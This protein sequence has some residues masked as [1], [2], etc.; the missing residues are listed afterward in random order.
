MAKN[1]ITDP[2][3]D[4]LNK[5]IKRYLLGN[6]GI[7]ESHHAKIIYYLQRCLDVSD[8]KISP[9]VR[10]EALTQGQRSG[11][12]CCLSG[13]T[14]DYDLVGQEHSEAT[15]KKQPDIEHKWPRS[16]GGSSF[17][18]N[19]IVSSVFYNR[20]KSDRIDGSD[21][22]YETICLKTDR[23]SNKTSFESEFD[24]SKKLAVL[25][26]QDY[27][28]AVCGK[29]VSEVGPLSFSRKQ[30]DDSW[31]FINIIALCGRHSSET[32]ESS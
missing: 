9:G 17:P 32:E 26:K 28:C 15:A 25:A 18:P 19:I 23:E 27:R 21:Y 10:N 16:M 5:C 29:T 2:M 22:H 4:R 30:V 24:S 13:E 3:D 7:S 11:G 8:K 1:S 31:H 6:T 14:L 20:K 12:L